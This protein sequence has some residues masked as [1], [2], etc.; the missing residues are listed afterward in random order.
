MRIEMSIQV[1]NE[2]ELGRVFNVYD[3]DRPIGGFKSSDAAMCLLE[4]QAYSK[5]LVVAR[6]ERRATPASETT[7]VCAIA[8]A[9]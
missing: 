8:F 3:G 1:H 2:I 7:P 6:T 5:C 9:D 4:E